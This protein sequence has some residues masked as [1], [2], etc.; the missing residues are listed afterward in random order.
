MRTE[1]L[2]HTGQPG[3]L[4]E[5]KLATTL[6]FS[7][8]DEVRWNGHTWEASR[9]HVA[10]V[11]PQKGAAMSVDLHLDNR[12][13][14]LESLFVDHDPRGAAVSIWRI[15]GDGQLASDQAVLLMTGEIDDVPDI[16]AVIN[17]GVTSEGR[18]SEFTPRHRLLPPLVNHPTTPGTI[19]DFGGERIVLGGKRS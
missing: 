16:D 6:R 13:M 19:I 5:L 9:V 11:Q 3:Y 2:Q 10:Q 7:T 18:L 15:D 8:R 12:D 1:P 14:S 17:I 4:V